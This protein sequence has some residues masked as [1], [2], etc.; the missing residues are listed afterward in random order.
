MNSKSTA[1]D[2]PLDK[3]LYVLKTIST[4]FC[5]NSVYTINNLDMFE[6]T[7]L[8]VFVLPLATNN[9]WF[10]IRQM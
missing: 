9:N 4:H 6:V 2:S 3:L 5:F 8:V 10:E 1:N 7:D